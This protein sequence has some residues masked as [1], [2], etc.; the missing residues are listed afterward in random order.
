MKCGVIVVAALLGGLLLSGCSQE[1]NTEKPAQTIP[2]TQSKP[3]EQEN[4]VPSSVETTLDIQE[5]ITFPDDTDPVEPTQQPAET[6]PE[7][8][9][10]W[11]GGI[12]LPDDDWD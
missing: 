5:E 8:Q 9:G 3:T 10:N 2:A 11:Q 1:N 4:Q 12:V 6:V 7:T